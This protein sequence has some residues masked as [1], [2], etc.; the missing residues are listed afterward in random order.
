R[1]VDARVHVRFDGQEAFTMRYA[2]VF[3]RVGNDARFQLAL[4]QIDPFHAMSSQVPADACPDV[5]LETSPDGFHVHTSVELTFEADG[6]VLAPEAGSYV[7]VFEDY[8]Q[9][10]AACL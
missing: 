7:G 10:Y 9:P 6:V 4:R 8:A 5:A 3:G 1:E 2:D